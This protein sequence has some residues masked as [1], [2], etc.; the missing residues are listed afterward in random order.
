[1]TYTILYV[2]DVPASLAFYQA[3][4]GLNTRF[5]HDIRAMG[6]AGYLPWA[7]NEKPELDCRGSLEPHF[8]RALK[9]LKL[10]GLPK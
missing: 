2:P 8:N 4:F 5:L 6:Y 1:M 10:P 7:W 9:T 3:A